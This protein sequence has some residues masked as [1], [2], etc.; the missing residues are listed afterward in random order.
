MIE[1]R[2]NIFPLPPVGSLLLELHCLKVAQCPLWKIENVCCLLSR[3]RHQL[4]VCSSG[5]QMG[6]CSPTG[7]PSDRLLHGSFG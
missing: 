2:V 7:S 3:A 6:L 5:D 4:T 1:A